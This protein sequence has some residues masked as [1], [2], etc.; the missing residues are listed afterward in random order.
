[1]GLIANVNICNHNDFVYNLTVENDVSYV[2]ETGIVHNCSCGVEQV[3]E[4]FIKD[5]GKT[6]RTND[7]AKFDLENG[8]PEQFRF[9]PYN[10]GILPKE[11]HS[12]FMALPN[13]NEADGS[14]FSDTE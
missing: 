8:V 5:S 9:N 1:M 12:Y 13:A 4:E 2:T 10:Q 11:G 3:D 6:P 14:M 7:E